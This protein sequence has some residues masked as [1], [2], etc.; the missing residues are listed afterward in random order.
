MKKS[1][2]FGCIIPSGNNYTEPDFYAQNQKDIYIYATRIYLKDITPESLRKMGEYTEAAA[3]LL[4]DT[5]ADIILFACTSGSLIEGIQW[6]ENLKKRITKNTG[7]PAITTSGSIVNALEA[8]NVKKMIVFAPYSE[9]LDRKEKIFFEN[10]HYEVLEIK[11]L[12][13]VDN[14]KIAAVSPETIYNNCLD[15]YHRNLEAEALFIS[16]TNLN[17]VDII[18]KIEKEIKIPVV[19][20]NQASY[21]KLL[22]ASGDNRKIKR[23]GRLLEQY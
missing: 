3:K 7:I 9:E 23:M 15:L 16:C 18:E 20:S 12:D 6:E 13:I 19:T 4:S 11:G 22:R 21:W 5:D 2:K 14:K 10:L 8:L 17:T 1:L